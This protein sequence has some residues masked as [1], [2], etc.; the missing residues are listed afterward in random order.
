[1]SGIQLPLPG[2]QVELNHP[3]SPVKVV[4]VP[5]HER[6]PLVPFS[7]FPDH[8]NVFQPSWKPT[9]QL[10]ILVPILVPVVVLFPGNALTPGAADWAAVAVAA[11]EA[12]T[13]MS[14]I[15]SKP[16]DPHKPGSI[17]SCVAPL[18]ISIETS[19]VTQSVLPAISGCDG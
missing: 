11:G 6:T 5:D 16:F 8:P 13:M 17:R 19:L 14:S 18:G 2:V 7:G 4:S 10:P 12:L 9:L 1:M 15:S 3:P